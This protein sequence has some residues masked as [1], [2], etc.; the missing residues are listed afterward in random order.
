M[1]LSASCYQIHCGEH[2]ALNPFLVMGGGPC[3]AAD[4]PSLWPAYMPVALSNYSRS[5]TMDRPTFFSSMS[6]IS[7]SR[8]RGWMARHS[9]SRQVA[10]RSVSSPATNV[11]H[12]NTLAPLF[13]AI[14]HLWATTLCT[15]G[16]HGGQ[17]HELEALAC[18][19][20]VVA[21]ALG[22]DDAPTRRR[23]LHVATGHLPM[24]RSPTLHPRCALL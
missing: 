8:Q 21:R 9:G 17:L 7:H 4:T 16:K 22:L 11:E 24:Y 2:A 20:Y 23:Q 6:D 14:R 19:G 12:N 13:C 18:R 5:D 10:G 3:L 1:I 15:L